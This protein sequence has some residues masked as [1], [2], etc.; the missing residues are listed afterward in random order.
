MNVY[1]LMEK[2]V[3]LLSEFPH[4][5]L[6][7]GLENSICA[8][9]YPLIRVVPNQNELDNFDGWAQDVYFSVFLGG[10]LD[11]LDLES[12]FR[13]IYTL[14]NE[15]WTKLHNFQ[16]SD[17]GAMV[18]FIRTSRRENEHFLMVECEYKIESVRL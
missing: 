16:W 11:P 3:D 13:R 1:E 5:S 14:E 18:R 10:F 12:E 15:I 8:D 9:D 17:I 7:I 6:K 2:V 4:K